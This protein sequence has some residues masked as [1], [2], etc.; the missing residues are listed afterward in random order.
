MN[1][2]VTQ[3]CRE[4]TWVIPSVMDNSGGVVN[5]ISDPI[6]GT[7]FFRGATVVAVTATD[8]F[9]NMNTCSFVV[10]VTMNG[11]FTVDAV[12]MLYSIPSVG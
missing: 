10:R 8:P 2:Q 3:E 5:V 4:V 6:S 7:C 9:N 11:E 12:S 1:L